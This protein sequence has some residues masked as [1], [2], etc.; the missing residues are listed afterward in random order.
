MRTGT[1]LLENDLGVQLSVG[2]LRQAYS[3]RP[4]RARMAA[5]KSAVTGNR[6]MNGR[7]VPPGCFFL[8]SDD[9]RPSLCV[10]DDIAAQQNGSSYAQT[11]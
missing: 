7:Y 4:I 9:E 3:T 10:V 8:A 6:K 1:S 2:R 11:S 5:N